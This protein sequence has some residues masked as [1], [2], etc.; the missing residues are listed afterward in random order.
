MDYSWHYRII[1]IFKNIPSKFNSTLFLRFPFEV[2]FSERIERLWKY[3][4]ACIVQR[5]RF[6]L[7]F[8]QIDTR[9]TVSKPAPLYWI[10]I[11]H[12]IWACSFV[13]IINFRAMH[14]FVVDQTTVSDSAHRAQPA[15]PSR[16]FS[17]L[18]TIV[19][20]MQRIEYYKRVRSLLCNWGYVTWKITSC[21]YKHKWGTTCAVVGID[22]FNFTV[23]FCSFCFCM[24]NYY[25]CEWSWLMSN[26]SGFAKFVCS[27]LAIVYISIM[28]LDNEEKT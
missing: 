11:T 10:T 9:D 3:T 6:I 24:I 2:I 18:Q 19:W 1:Y 17:V 28:F 13:I 14:A 27:L 20:N 22:T 21:L 12:R 4:Y 5:Q 16:L 25:A 7:S 15:N 26:H 8:T 23:T